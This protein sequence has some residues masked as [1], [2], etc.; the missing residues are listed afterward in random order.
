MKTKS[1]EDLVIIQ[2]V[3]EE[4]QRLKGQ[5][6]E[7]GAKF[8]LFDGELSGRND[9]FS[10]FA[11]KNRD[12]DSKSQESWGEIQ[13]LLSRSR[14]VLGE[15]TVS[16]LSDRYKA[17]MNSISRRLLWVQV[18][19][20]LSLVFVLVSGGAAF[21]FFPWLESMG[22]TR[23]REMPAATSTDWGPLLVYWLSNSFGKL[24]LLTPA[25]LMV[26]F[27]LKR[28]SELARLQSE[29]T[30]KYTVAASLAGFK[31]E[32][33]THAEAIVAAAFKEMLYNPMEK[34]SAGPQKDTSISWLERLLTPHIKKVFDKVV[35]EEK[36]KK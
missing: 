9:L 35:E 15:A 24:I 4:S 7:Y 33:P 8:N 13:R 34:F 14:E 23:V 21:G 36:E 5:I 25:F 28:Q 20:Y 18:T 30:F 1:E 17:E 12:F 26:V 22:I 27:T 6:E 19:F 11:D 32:A 3:L 10:K 31:T 2:K 29:Y 16:G